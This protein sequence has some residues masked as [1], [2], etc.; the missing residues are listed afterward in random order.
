MGWFDDIVGFVDRN[1]DWIKPVVSIGSSVLKQKQVDNTQ[2][3]YLDYLR[4][5]EIENYQNSVNDINYY[6]AQGEAAAGNAAANRAA[7]A[8]NRAAATAAARQTE[9]NRMKAAKKSNKS[10]QKTYKDIL[11]L[12]RP[13]KETADVL[14]PQMT[15]TYQNS[16]GLQNTLGQFLQNP[17]QMAKLNSSVPAWN[18]NVPLPDSVR[19]K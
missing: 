15:Q 10:L 9:A 19:I 4:Q 16:L 12:Y 5:R 14:L 11:E 13:Y 2:Q 8:A 1:K 3:E 18:I 17:A 6:N 7:S